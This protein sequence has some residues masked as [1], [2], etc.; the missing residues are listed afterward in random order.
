MFRSEEPVSVFRIMRKQLVK[1]FRN[2]REAA[3]FLQ[4]TLKVYILTNT[5]GTLKIPQSF[6]IL[7]IDRVNDA[8]N[9]IGLEQFLY[10]A[11][12]TIILDSFIYMH[13]F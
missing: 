12:P 11:C 3:N 5:R 9:H 6:R 8:V 10:Q 4:D 7:L 13:K 2:F 1:Q